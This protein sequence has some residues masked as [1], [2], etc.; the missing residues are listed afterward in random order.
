MPLSGGEPSL[1]F[2]DPSYDVTS[3][4]FD[5]FTNAPIGY[6]VGGPDPKV[7]WTDPKLESIQKAVSKAF[8]GKSTFVF[9]RSADYKRII[10][11]V[12]SPTSPPVYYLV[13]FGKG[14]ADIIGEAYPMLADARWVNSRRRPTRRRTVTIFPPT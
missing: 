12:E 7:V 3:V 4:R 11:E 5:R 10:A 14:T 9:D 8:A 1:L 6:T 13:D 2:E